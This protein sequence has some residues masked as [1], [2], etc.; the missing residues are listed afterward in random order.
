[1]KPNP[2]KLNA[3]DAIRDPDSMPLIMKRAIAGLIINFKKGDRYSK[4][5]TDHERFTSAFNIISAQFTREGIIMG[6]K[7][8]LELTGQGEVL[9]EQLARKDREE[10]KASL[11][12]FKKASL[13]QKKKIRA[14]GKPI[15]VRA[16]L[17]YLDKIIERLQKTL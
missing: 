5:G 16:K 12:R 13:E 17:V 14:R 9:Q 11:L 10:K 2:F 7:G 1:M 3:D 8:L 15:T 6:R 4:A